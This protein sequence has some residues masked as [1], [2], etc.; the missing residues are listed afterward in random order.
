[1]E[2]KVEDLREHVCKLSEIGLTLCETGF[3]QAHVDDVLAPKWDKAE[4]FIAACHLFLNR[5]FSANCLAK[6]VYPG[7]AHHRSCHGG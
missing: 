2:F 4:L 3:T 1:V 5:S 6:L 7:S